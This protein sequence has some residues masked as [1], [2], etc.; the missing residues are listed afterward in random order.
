[1]SGREAPLFTIFTATFNR[2]HTIR[3]VYDSLC[4]QTL[5]DFEW[6][7]ID[8]GSTD[9]TADRV[10]AWS[11]AADF[12]I[13]YLRQQ[14]AGK[15]VAH[16]LAIREARGQ[17]FAP[18]DSDDAI[19]PD[20]LK[21]IARAWNAIPL[22]ER[23][24]FSGVWGLCRNQH[25]DVIGDRF[26]ANPFDADL[27]DVFYVHRVGGEKWGVSRTDVLRRFPFPEIA[28]TQFIPESRVWLE[29][30]KTYRAR[31]VNDVIRIYHVGDAATGATLS[32]RKSLGENA[33]GR[34]HYYAWLLDGDLNYFF[35]SPMPFVKAAV[36]LPI[37]ARYSG[38]PL[39]GVI[40]ALEKFPAK[41]LVCAALPLAALLYR[42]DRLRTTAR[43]ASARAVP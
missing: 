42:F 21:T 23:D 32:E 31:C 7:V 2:G 27:R 34:L 19:P 43:R 8:D 37:V 20:S 10:A 15:H 13:R 18:L 3:R 28:D 29:V 40:A 1:M 39:P 26:P 12:P 33:P 24:R 25:G 9:D 4:A 30:A 5:R 14:H 22:S 17:L 6:L 41:I 11:K 16:N 38:K 36:M 35:R